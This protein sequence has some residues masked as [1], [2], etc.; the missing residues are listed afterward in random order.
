MSLA[1]IDSKINSRIYTFR[2]VSFW[3]MF[4]FILLLGALVFYAYIDFLGITYR[5]RFIFFI[6][7]I[8][9]SQISLGLNL[10]FFG[11]I[12]FLLGGD[13]YKITN[14]YSSNEARQIDLKNSPIAV[15]MPIYNENVDRVFAGVQ[16]MYESLQEETGGDAFDFF[17][18]SDSKD[19]N[20]WIEEEIRWI[21]L[22]K[23]LNAFGRIFYRIRKQN[24]NKKSGNIAD[25]CRRW[26]KRYKYMIVLDADSLMTGR[27]MVKLAKLMEI[28][29]NVGILQSAPKLFRG[30]TFFQRMM[31]FGNQLYSFLFMTGSNY[32]H[33]GGGVYWGHNAII[34]LQ[35]FI[36]YCGLPGLPGTHSTIG[37]KI[38]SHDTIEAALIH[39]SGYSV[40]FA[41]D[42]DE[43]YEECPPN[44]IE[45][46]KR[47][48]RWCQGNLQ[49]FWFLFAKG[50]RFSN[51]L[52]IFIGILS[53]ASAPLWGLFILLS[54]I[55][56]VYESTYASLFLLPEEWQYLWLHTYLP[57]AYNLFFYTMG[58][59]F[60]PKFLGLFILL[61]RK[62]KRRQMGGS[63]RVCISFLT[64]L[65]FSV[66]L[67]PI[68]MIMYSKFVIS[69]ILGKVIKWIPQE[70]DPDKPLTFRQ[71][72]KVH[73]DQTLCGLVLAFFTYFISIYLFYWLL[74]IW[75][76][77]I[78]S[79]PYSFITSKIS[80]GE[81]LRKW[82]IFLTKEETEPPKEIQ[83][84][85][86]ILEKDVDEKFTSL[87]NYTGLIKVILDPYINSIHTSLL[88][89]KKK[90]EFKT[91][92][93]T[94]EL[95]ERLFWNGAESLSTSEQTRILLDPET[96]FQLHKRIWI[97]PKEKLHPWWQKALNAYNENILFSVRKRFA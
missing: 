29:P 95:S 77:C 35:P 26:G 5:E 84:L 19:N 7:I 94:Q 79:I 45:S 38:L 52:H 91:L 9:F 62:E 93:H 16:A 61:I 90:K 14:T 42:I 33:L 85:Y 54:L 56:Y 88:L 97:T 20:K 37:G 17:V 43:S 18:L 82:G 3:G 23:E 66:F 24:I 6:F 32:W 36:E 30:R 41:Y 74:P 83:R 25:F 72:I 78:L 96:L 15:V 68:L 28:N 31:Q 1:S 27:A 49:H 47:D 86:E 71:C 55:N 22:C 64:E 12:Q 76:G 4:G 34:R 10:S 44:L 51:R 73:L 57:R 89:Q 40:W 46:L 59:L 75:L 39:K 69:T 50:I 63:L 67:A 87:E 48:H 58:V 53:Y 2:N 80:I 81:K 11:I 13:K 21:K 65:V 92:P 70:R 60:L 8:L